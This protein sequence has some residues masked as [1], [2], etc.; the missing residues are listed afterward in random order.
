ML[1]RAQ[2]GKHC[3]RGQWVWRVRIAAGVVAFCILIRPAH[4]MP[5]SPMVASALSGLTV[6]VIGDL[7]AVD[8]ER[9]DRVLL[10]G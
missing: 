2:T 1:W 9:P 5:R 10:H 6:A 3:E 7:A 8:A 4:V